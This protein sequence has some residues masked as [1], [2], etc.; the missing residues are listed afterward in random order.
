MTLGDKQ[1]WR[2]IDFCKFICA[3][4]VIAIHCPPLDD[5]SNILSFALKNIFCRVAVPFFFIAAGFFFT[6][7]ANQKRK[8]MGYVSRLLILYVIYTFFYK[9]TTPNFMFFYSSLLFFLTFFR[10]SS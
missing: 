1:E 7:K 10:V 5:F 6:N 3:I 9:L 4:M 8:A 2:A